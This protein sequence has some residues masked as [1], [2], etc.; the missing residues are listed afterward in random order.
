[1]ILGPTK[2]VILRCASLGVKAEPHVRV[3]SGVPSRIV[4]GRAAGVIVL[5]HWMMT[6]REKRQDACPQKA[7]PAPMALR[8]DNPHFSTLETEALRGMTELSYS[9]WCALLIPMVLKTRTAFSAFLATTIQLSQR[10]T[11][12]GPLAPTFYPIPVPPGTLFRM[13]AGCSAKKRRGIHLSKAVHTV[14]M[15]LNFWFFGGNF[16]ESSLLQREPNM[17]HRCLFQRIGALI[18]SDVPT[19]TFL[20]P[21]MGRKFPELI[22]HLNRVSQLF[23]NL[24]VAGDP[25]ERVYPGVELPP[26]GDLDDDIQPYTDLCPERLVFHGSG[27]WDVEE[28]LPDDLA[29]AF[30]EPKTIATGRPSPIKPCLR[31]S[32]ER[33]AELALKWDNHSLLFIHSDPVPEDGLVRI[34][35][36]RKSAVQDRQ[37]GD[38]R[39]QNGLEAKVIGPSADLPSGVDVGDLCVNPAKQ[40]VAVS[41]SD[42][43]DFYH[44]LQISPEKAKGNTLG[45]PVPISS[46]EGTQALALWVSRQKSNKRYRRLLHGD[47]LGFIEDKGLRRQTTFGFLSIVCCRAIT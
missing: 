28:F 22:A 2:T 38:K 3:T 4:L 20:V 35:N 6:K 14:C 26:K 37:I 7:V 31:D 9:K 45:P 39:G 24:G 10:T 17:Q 34:F 5:R 18:K 1:M 16:I 41:I 19:G 15:A 27:Q 43:R 47:K 13:P 33:I 46:V 12:R 23:T 32:P 30:R 29:M 21:K 11:G 36:A 42:R 44:Q 25:Y 40:Y 8:S